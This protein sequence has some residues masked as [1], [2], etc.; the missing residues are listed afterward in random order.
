[1]SKNTSE[2]DV[3][4]RVKQPRPGAVQPTFPTMQ[5]CQLLAG[6]R[7]TRPVKKK[8]IKNA[9]ELLGNGSEEAARNEATAV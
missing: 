3:L 6:T 4:L 7:P 8:K 9:N 2:G 5:C 1:M